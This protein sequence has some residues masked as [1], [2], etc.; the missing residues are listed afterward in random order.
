MR[1]IETEG[2]DWMFREGRYESPEAMF[3]A[4]EPVM[5]GLPDAPEQ[6]FAEFVKARQAG[7]DAQ[8]WARRFIEGFH[9]AR[10]EEIGVHGLAAANRAGDAIGGDRTFR[11]EGGYESLIEWLQR[12]VNAEI[13]YGIVVKSVAWQRGRVDVRTGSGE[14]HA[15][16][17]ICTAPIGVL[18]ARGLRFDPEPDRLRAALEAIAMGHAARIALRF[19]RAVWEDRPELRGLGFLF[20][21]ETTMPTW[22]TAAPAHEPL[23]VGWTGGPAAEALPA[24]IDA[25]PR[26]VSARRK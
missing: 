3:Q 21:E 23:I 5:R 1:A 15:D 13:R 6:S 19:R 26:R 16:R 12:G 7:A 9:A 2:A 4:T 25:W 14:F 20:S 10:T 8:Q 11:L 24:D 17:L 18:A 22:W